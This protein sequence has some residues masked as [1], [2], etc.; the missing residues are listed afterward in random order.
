MIQLLWWDLSS[1]WK[2]N[3]ML[4]SLLNIFHFHLHHKGASLY[5]S[6]QYI[7]Y[8]ITFFVKHSYKGEA[9]IQNVANG[10]IMIL[11]IFLQSVNLRFPALFSSVLVSAFVW[12]DL[13]KIFHRC[14]L[15]SCQ[16]RSLSS[17][18]IIHKH[19]AG[20]P[21]LWMRMDMHQLNQCHLC[22]GSFTSSSLPPPLAPA[23]LHVFD[24]LQVQENIS[25]ACTQSNLALAI[26]WWWSYL[27]YAVCIDT[28]CKQIIEV[29]PSTFPSLCM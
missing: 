26:L 18:L 14:C 5:Q 9:E 25:F 21:C 7:V 6:I 23:R 8:V 29:S 19:V 2:L 10:L 13:I 16:H 4:S 22:L 12:L 24:I 11:S 15:D 27:D 1:V 17:R 3:V 20:Y 28:M